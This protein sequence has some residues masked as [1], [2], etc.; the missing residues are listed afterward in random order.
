MRSQR[1]L[2]AA[3]VAAWAGPAW[4]QAPPAPQPDV[5]AWVN[6]QTIPESH[7]TRLVGSADEHAQGTRD[8]V[9]SE[10]LKSLIDQLLLDQYLKQQQITI[11]KAELDRQLAD[12]RK[13]VESNGKNFA[14]FL[15]EG[16][17]TEAELCEQ[18]TTELR[19]E[20]YVQVHV[21]EKT[22]REMFEAN[23]EAFDGT[24]VRVRHVMLT[25]ASESLR[26]QEK[27]EAQLLALKKQVEEQVAAG[28]ARL[29]ASVDAATRQKVRGQL[30]EEAFAAVA[31]EKSVCPSRVEG[32]N[33]HWM[34]RTGDQ[35]EPFA[36]MAFRLEPF[37]ISPVVKTP[38][39]LHLILVT[40][41][42]AGREIKFDDIKDDVRDNYCDRLRAK[43]I[44]EARS[45]GRIVIYPGK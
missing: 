34:H 20:K 16:N 23:K 7:V 25:P 31:R 14:E 30:M 35:S 28:L 45:K 42:K 22:L 32:G 12:I 24:M 36:A 38:F 26:D 27:V 19:W 10:A 17:L 37:Q 2:L 44:A 29:P 43:L 15:R 18:L 9:R 6:G 33:I 39:G 21:T 13:R 8:K 3:V 40:D 4:A 41:R 11:D 1:L 5:A